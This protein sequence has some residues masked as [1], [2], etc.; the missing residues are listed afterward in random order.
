MA[1][2]EFPRLTHSAIAVLQRANTANHET[3]VGPGG[4]RPFAAAVIREAVKQAAP[5]NLDN[6]VDMSIQ[7]VIPSH[8]PEK[9]KDFLVIAIQDLMDI[10]DNL[11]ALPPPSPTR[12]EMDY[13][14]THLWPLLDCQPGSK[15]D[16]YM[17]I[18]RRGIAHHCKEQP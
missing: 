4:V 3:Y 10:A 13:A 6:I 18:L 16:E 7:Q 1:H 5:F 8:Q 15:G 14:L 12:E 2:D 17:Q 9:R 11:H